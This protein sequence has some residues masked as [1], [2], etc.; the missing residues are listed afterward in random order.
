MNHLDSSWF[1]MNQHE[2]LVTSWIILNHHESSWITLTHLESSWIILNH[3]ESSW[4]KLGKAYPWSL[5]LLSPVPPCSPLPNTSP[6]KSSKECTPMAGTNDCTVE[7]LMLKIC[8]SLVMQ[9]KRMAT[10]INGK[11][12]KRGILG[13]FMLICCLFCFL[14]SCSMFLPYLWCFMCWG[15][16]DNF[17]AKVICWCLV[18]VRVGFV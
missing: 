6:S 17:D 16:W 12:G 5:V 10:R 4:I 11:N 3:L 2:H 18:W 13:Q 8:W 15:F 7:C 9:K 14:C 1:I